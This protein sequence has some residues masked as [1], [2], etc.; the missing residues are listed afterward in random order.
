MLPPARALADVDELGLG[1]HEGLVAVG[2]A[3]AEAEPL[4][5]AVDGD[6]EDAERV[7]FV[8]GV[9]VPGADLP[10]PLGHESGDGV[11]AL[12]DVARP[13]GEQL[14]KEI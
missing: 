5:L 9:E 11:V 2:D 4:A 13:R 10:V 8:E 6:G 1:H 12:A 3:D 7:D 14:L